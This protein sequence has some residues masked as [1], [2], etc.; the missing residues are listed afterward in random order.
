MAA[1]DVIPGLGAR[2]NTW[3]PVVMALYCTSVALSGVTQRCS[4]MYAL[5][6]G[7]LTFDQEVRGTPM[8]APMPS[9]A[10]KHWQ[11]CGRALPGLTLRRQGRRL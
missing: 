9:S 4:C 10:V 1:M 6:P 3:F 7:R 5:L 11:A 2:F 8:L